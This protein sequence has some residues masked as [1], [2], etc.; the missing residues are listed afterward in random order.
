MTVDE[1]KIVMTTM[2][3]TPLRLANPIVA[4]YAL[5]SKDKLFSIEYVKSLVIQEKQ[6]AEM[7]DDKSGKSCDVS[8][9]FSSGNESLDGLRCV[10]RLLKSPRRYKRTNFGCERNSADHY[11]RSDVNVPRR[12][13][14]SMAAH[15]PTM[16]TN[17]VPLLVK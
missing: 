3:K 7:R 8:A 11:R 1:K 4:L 15:F 9:L 13:L 10:S 16:K 2:G 17:R 14:Q 5:R 6:C 12:L